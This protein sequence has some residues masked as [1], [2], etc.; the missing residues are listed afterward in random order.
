MRQSNWTLVSGAL[1]AVLI[2]SLG[3]IS[4]GVGAVP[5]EAEAQ[6]FITLSGTVKNSSG[7]GISQAKVYIEGYK[8]SGIPSSVHVATTD[9]NG[10]WS[11]SSV[12]NGYTY[13]VDASKFNYDRDRWPNSIT[14]STPNIN[15]VIDTQA[16]KVL[17]I[18]MVADEEF[19]SQ[20]PV[21]Q[22][23]A[24]SKISSKQQAFYMD[25]FNLYFNKKYT[26]TTWNSPNGVTAAES[27]MSDAEGDTGWG[28][29]VYQ[30]AD[31]MTI[32]TRQTPF[33]CA[34]DLAAV[35]CGEVPGTS[36]QHPVSISNDA[37]APNT[38]D[39]VN[40]E[41]AHNYGFNH[42]STY[43]A[44]TMQADGGLGLKDMT[45]LSPPEDD[46]MAMDGSLSKRLWY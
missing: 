21:W 5:Q 22:T 17:D 15:L 38:T 16:S 26:Y 24:W 45:T 27:L 39:T 36:G 44:T 12:K 9:V 14:T 23:T 4:Y 29:G 30:G 41:L 25:N 19:R 31:V 7:T 42:I 35:G 1:M 20:Y 3:S 43:Y 33:S 32:L 13:T 11:I 37:E 2:A 10:V 6:T 18:Y 8:T 40:H 34:G 46:D 28:G